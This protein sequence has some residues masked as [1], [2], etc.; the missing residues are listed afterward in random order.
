MVVGILDTVGAAVVVA[1]LRIV[2]V[3]LLG[4]MLDVLQEHG[5]AVLAAKITNCIL[6]A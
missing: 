3:V 1:N 4:A 2:G 6:L 5:S